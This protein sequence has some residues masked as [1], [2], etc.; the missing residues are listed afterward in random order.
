MRDQL[1]TIGAIYDWSREIIT[2]DPAYYKYTQWLFLQFYK[3]GLAYKKKVHANWCVSCKTILANEQVVDEKC[4]RCGSDVIKKDIEQWLL[5]ITDKKFINRLITDLDKVD[6]PEKTKTMQKNWIGKSEGAEIKFLI[7]KFSEI[8]F[9]TSNPSKKARVE[10]LIRKA[11]LSCKIYLPKDLC[12]EETEVEEGG[13][14]L[15]NAK[16]KAL[17]YRGKV[18]MPILAVDSGFFINDKEV[19]PVQV[20]RNALA[21]LD[22]KSLN[23]EKIANKILDYYKKIATKHGGETT[24]YWIDSWALVL[25]NGKIEIAKSRRE[26]I[27]TNKS[28]GEVDI[29]FPIRSLYKV[30][31]T[32][33]YITEQT[34][35]DELTEL[36]PITGALTKLLT[37]WLEIF[38]TR[39]DTIFGAT[40]MVVCPEHKIIKNQESRIK[41][42]EQVKK[43][44]QGSLKKSDLQRTDLAKEKTG[45]ALQGI[46]AINPANNQEIPIWVADYILPHYGTGAIMAVPDIDE[47]DKEFAKKYNLPIVKTKLVDSEKIIKQL[48]AKKKVNYKLR[49]WLI[50]RQRY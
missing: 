40:Y 41:N 4:E 19:N 36:L 17:A 47:R 31:S 34:E 18:N 29:Y 24:A 50:S 46:K 25:P 35:K 9:A 44:I 38:T 14:L 49:D 23:Q 13:S 1:K 42:Y 20:K 11:G 37:Q 21:G 33:K 30:K 5:K 32:G 3:H 22:E 10:K 27:L 12:I 8:L 45:I 15:N 28:M 48:G 26:V 7:P 2:C 16:K 6:W 43:Y 39:P